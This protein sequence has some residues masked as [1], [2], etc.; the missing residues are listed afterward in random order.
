MEVED[1]NEVAVPAAIVPE[2]LP[3]TLGQEVLEEVPLAL[4]DW[5]EDWVTFAVGGA[6]GEEMGSRVKVKAPL[7][8][9]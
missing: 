9:V 3:L 8:V 4:R 1:T 6:V 2:P 5:V 7:A